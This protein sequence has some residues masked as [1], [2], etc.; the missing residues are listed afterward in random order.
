MLFVYRFF[1]NLIFVFSPL[2]FFFRLINKK[3]TFKSFKEKVGLFRKKR[4]KGKLIWFHGASVGELQSIIPLIEKF[5]KEITITQILITSNT[6]SSTKIIEK[7]KF[8][9]VIHQFF[10]IDNNFISQK[11]INHWCPNKVFFIDSE[12]WPNMLLNLRN[13]NI[14]TIL[15]NGRITKKT[16]NRWKFFSNFSKEIFS[17]FNLCLASSR[18]SYLFLK[19]LGTKNLKLIGNLKYSQSDTKIINL[20]NKLKN[21]IKNKKVWCASSTHDLEEVIC[22]KI[23]IRLKKRIKNLLTIIIPRHIERCEKIEKDLCKL[24]LKVHAENS[25]NSILSKT[26]IYLV[27]SYGKTKSFFSIC[28]K[29]FLGGSLVNHGGQ[30]PLEAARLGCNI[31]N[32]PHIQ[33]FTEIYEFLEKLKISNKIKN[34]DHLYNKLISLFIKKKG[35]NKLNQQ[36]K[37]IGQNILKKTYKEIKL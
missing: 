2:I 1:I 8:K 27:N 36:L 25:T 20:N 31:L 24:G 34:Q 9:K 4:T 28:N 23:H 6:L 22:G 16:F 15:L 30:N 5:D 7:L 17:C 19:T 13:K 12:I 32:G 37:V 11:F 14:E 29:V 26:D 18:Q 21:F 10:P 3:E 33:N 35:V